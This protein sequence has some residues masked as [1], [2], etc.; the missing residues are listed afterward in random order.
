MRIGASTLAAALSAAPAHAASADWAPSNP[1][2]AEVRGEVKGPDEASGDGVYGRFDGDLEI[3]LGLGAELDFGAAVRPSA[4]L[5]LHYFAMAGVYVSYGD[6]FGASDTPGDAIRKLGLGVD[7]RPVFV[8][9]WANAMEAGPA[10]LDLTLDSI[11]L[12]LGAFWAEPE[13]GSFGD[14]RGFETSLGFGVPLFGSAHGL[15][16]EA[17]GALRWAD[18]GGREESI[19]ALLSWHSFV[20]T[21]LAR[22]E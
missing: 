6:A 8:P 14:Q 2:T 11:S 10:I 13:G 9:R 15:W 22:S 18:D 5:A 7:L 1:T 17:R 4:Q 20:L 12:A 21:P 3:G 19:F 16:I